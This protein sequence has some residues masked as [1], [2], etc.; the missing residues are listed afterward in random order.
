MSLLEVRIFVMILLFG[1][2]MLIG[3]GPVFLFHLWQKKRGTLLLPDQDLSSKHA[4]ILHLL[5]VFG[6][7]VLLA[8]CFVHMI[9]EITENYESFMSRKNN[10]SSENE[11]LLGDDEK[12]DKVPWVEICVCIGLFITYLIDTSVVMAIEKSTSHQQR[13]EMNLPENNLDNENED[14]GANVQI[15]SYRTRFF[16]GLII[17][18]A[19]L[20]HSIFDG[21]AIGLQSTT[22]SIWTVFFAICLHKFVVVFAIGFELFQKTA[23]LTLT[24]IHLAIFSATSPFGILLTLILEQDGL[25]EDGSLTIIL[26]SAIATGAILYIV[27]LEILRT[28]PPAGINGLVHLTT[29]VAGFTLMSVISIVVGD[30]D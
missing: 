26:F 15:L 10:G 7:G 16:K 9:P 24:C 17:V 12:K 30:G 27:F 22:T 11:G 21:V 13:N 23:S 8:T 14:S 6:G 25:A 2:T 3:Y 18:I 1:L 5:L 19:F 28:E 4:K 20:A 29:L